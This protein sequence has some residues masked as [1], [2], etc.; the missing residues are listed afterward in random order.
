MPGGEACYQVLHI[1]CLEDIDL[2]RGEP[3]WLQH[4]CFREKAEA[5][6]SCKG[7]GLIVLQGWLG[8]GRGHELRALEHMDVW[9]SSR[10]R[11]VVCAP[12]SRR[13][14]MPGNPGMLGSSYVAATPAMVVQV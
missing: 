14:K 1:C 8:E 3:L 12:S 10:N 6:V 2:S 9:L 7:E 11:G 5:N 4:Q 13:A